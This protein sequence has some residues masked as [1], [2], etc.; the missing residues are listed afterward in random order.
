MEPKLTSRNL[1]EY[2]SKGIEV[3]EMTG[4]RRFGKKY[5]I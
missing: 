4:R 2:D 1:Y 5:H 3:K